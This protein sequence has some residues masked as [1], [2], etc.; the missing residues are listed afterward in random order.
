[1]KI[2]RCLSSVV[3]RLL[4]LVFFLIGELA[5]AQGWVSVQ[6]VG[7]LPENTAEVN[8]QHLQAAIDEMSPRGGVLYVEPTQGGYPMQ[9][10]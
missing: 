2:V 4:F 3:Y 10:G 7:V 5:S 1:M 9:G 6:A 8:R